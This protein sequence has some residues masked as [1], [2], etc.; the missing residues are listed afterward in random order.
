[1]DLLSE[2]FLSVLLLNAKQSQ[3]FKEYLD[4]LLLLLFCYFSKA[5]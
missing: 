2:F 4:R 5:R 3:S 1:M